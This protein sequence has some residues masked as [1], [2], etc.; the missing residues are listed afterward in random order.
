V[1]ITGIDRGYVFADNESVPSSVRDST[2]YGTLSME[3]ST[4]GAIFWGIT[5]GIIFVVGY[6]IATSNSD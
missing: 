6:L 4:Q 1:W 3:A 5:Y 2:K